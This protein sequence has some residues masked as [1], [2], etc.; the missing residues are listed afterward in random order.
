[1]KKRKIRLAACLL[2][3][4]MIIGM[5]ASPVSAAETAAQMNGLS[6]V[7]NDAQGTEGSALVADVQ[8]TI[9]SS[10]ESEAAESETAESEEQAD[11]QEYANLAVA[12]VNDYVN[13]RSAA[14]T[15]SEI[16]GRMENSA[17]AVV[18]GEENGWYQITSGSVS[19]YVLAEYLTVG[20]R[21]LLESV[22]ARAATVQAQFLRV[23]SEASLDA[24]VRMLVSEGTQLEVLD[25]NTE[26]WVHVQVSDTDG[27]VSADY[28]TVEDMY[29]YAKTQEEVSS[30]TAVV[31]YALQFVGNP[32]VWG[33]TSL[34]NGAD[35]SGFIM[36]VY[37]NFGV[38]LPHSS[39]ALRSVGTGVSYSEAQPG[40]II[41]YSGHV[42]LYIG[43]GQVVHAANERKGIIVSSAT[44][45]DII[46]V[47]RIFT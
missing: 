5:G 27:Y 2:A 26:G 17:V 18:E 24:S 10:A 28:V 25:E 36:S 9:E 43:N 21:E 16:V 12:V 19:G 34:T 23:R 4:S 20:D 32:Y 8:A 6:I 22:R 45:M 7:L 31:S 11:D 13:V 30:G 38:S 41:C 35:C 1:M 29:L 40:D 46:A 3:G 15:D 33:G 14:S 39:A 42:A 44:H 37:A 47:R